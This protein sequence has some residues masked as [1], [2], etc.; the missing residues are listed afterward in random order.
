M[1]ATRSCIFWISSLSNA[2][3]PLLYFT[4]ILITLSFLSISKSICVPFLVHE[5]AVLIT[6]KNPKAFLI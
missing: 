4:Q 6:L 3:F 2:Y 1:V 5:C